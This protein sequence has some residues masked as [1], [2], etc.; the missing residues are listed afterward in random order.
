MKYAL[1]TTF[2]SALLINGCGGGGDSSPKQSTGNI[3][4]MQALGKK[5]FFDTTLSSQNNQSCA[6][7]HD[8]ANGF[9]DGNTSVSAPVSPGSVSGRFGNRNAPTAAYASFIPDFARTA[10]DTTPDGTPSNYRGGQFLDGRRPNLMEQAKDPFLNPAEM[11]NASAAEVVSKVQSGN[12][13]T[14]FTDV[15]GSNAFADSNV[16]YDNIA[17]AIAAF[18]A[19]AEVNKFSSKFDDVM[20]GSDSFSASEQRGF[21]LF[22]GSKAKCANCHTIP[23]SGPVLFSNFRYYN[24]GVPSNPQNPAVIADASYIDNGLAENSS[25]VTG[26]IATTAGKFRTP[27]LRNI[28]LT[29]PYMHNG[30]YTTLEQVISHYDIQVSQGFVTPEVGNNI[31]NELTNNGTSLGLSTTEQA[32]LVNFLKTLTDR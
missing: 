18:E 29:A 27:T 13:A 2:I 4:A 6:S 28:A 25:V 26:D 9:A 14:D 20:R 3:A 7:C 22:K 8:P 19:S 11:N 5:I 21:D 12:Y 32:D 31:A 1:L 17:R 15:F 23:D 16:A 24:I 30:I 10:T